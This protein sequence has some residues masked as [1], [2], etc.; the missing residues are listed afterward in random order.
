MCFAE[1]YYNVINK[2][3]NNIVINK[4]NNNLKMNTL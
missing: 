1:M 2:D 3:N 4:D